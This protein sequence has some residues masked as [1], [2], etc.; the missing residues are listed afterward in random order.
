M[1]FPFYYLDKKPHIEV[2]FRIRRDRTT[3]REIFVILQDV[4][5]LKDSWN[6]LEKMFYSRNQDIGESIQDFSIAL[7]EI[8]MKMDKLRQSSDDGTDCKLKDRFADGVHD[9]SLRRE[10]NRLNKER[11]TL[12]FYQLRDEALD[13]CKK[14]DDPA[15]ET[16]T[17]E[18][19]TAQEATQVSQMMQL[20]QEQQSQLSILTEAVNTGQY[21]PRGRGRGKYN[22]GRGNRGRNWT[23]NRDVSA[24]PPQTS[25]PQGNQAS[26]ADKPT[27]TDTP[28]TQTA[29]DPI[30]CHY[31]AQP[32]H[33][34]R[35]CIKRRNDR[36][37]QSTWSTNYHHSN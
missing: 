21:Q 5:G 10:L 17:V 37:G 15:K 24:P 19:A 12:R 18:S 20:L 11:P 9:V 27:S 4:Y 35:N 6:T 29:E 2:K 25:P 7:M 23:Q 3:A 28:P 31:C 36:R 8:L 14:D 30:I 33:I 1:N 26:P 34:E 13:W 16:A 22:R 32:N